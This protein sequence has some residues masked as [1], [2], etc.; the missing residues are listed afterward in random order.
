MKRTLLPYAV[1]LGAM[2]PGFAVEKP[3]VFITESQSVQ[4][5]GAAAIG[6]TKGA[7]SLTG[8][9]SPANIEV[10]KTFLQRCPAVVV[11]ANRD[12]ADY[13]IRLDHEAVGPTTP[14]V[15]GNKVAVFDKNDELIYS[16]TTKFL[17]NAVKNAC[18][19]ITTR[20]RE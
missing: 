3:R 2:A 18:A 13:V 5:A 14:F 11:T 19:A 6:E 10:M 17:G 15:R 20:T 1:A 8:G 7:L 9:T 4:L 16:N 12:K